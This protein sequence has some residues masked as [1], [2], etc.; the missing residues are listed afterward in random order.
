MKVIS[1]STLVAVICLWQLSTSVELFVLFK[2]IMVIDEIRTVDYY[3]LQYNLLFF[4]GHDSLEVVIY[5]YIY[6]L[7]CCTGQF[8]D[9]SQTECY[10]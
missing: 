7:P 5:I 8:T 6:I 1:R 4:W 2:Y 10:M 9:N 3:F